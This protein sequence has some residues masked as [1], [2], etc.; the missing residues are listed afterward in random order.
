MVKRLDPKTFVQFDQNKEVEQKLFL[1]DERDP[2]SGESTG[3]F[4]FEDQV[5]LLENPM[6]VSLTGQVTIPATAIARSFFNCYE[7]S[8]LKAS[9]ADGWLFIY[10]DFAPGS[11]ADAKQL[12][13]KVYVMKKKH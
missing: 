9:F 8:H 5:Y 10:K 3:E 13:F 6:E 11:D 4:D 1:Y 12:M 2:T 7:W